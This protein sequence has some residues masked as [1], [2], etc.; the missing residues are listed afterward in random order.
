M[1]NAQWVIRRHS[2]SG[3]R[4]HTLYMLCL[5]SA[6]LGLAQLQSIM[7]SRCHSDPDSYSALYSLSLVLPSTLSMRGSAT[8]LGL[9]LSRNAHQPSRAT[10]DGFWVLLPRHTN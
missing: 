1:S 8:N 2:L 5:A 7:Y 10:E 3:L 9:R 6:H 4:V